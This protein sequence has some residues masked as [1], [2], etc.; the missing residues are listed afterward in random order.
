MS[1]LALQRHFNALSKFAS[2]EP[3]VFGRKRQRDV[4]FYTPINLYARKHVHLSV[5]VGLDTNNL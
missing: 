5:A 1:Y 2:V 4:A 3:R